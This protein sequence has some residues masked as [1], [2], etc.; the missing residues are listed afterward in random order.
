MP[1]SVGVLSGP[2]HLHLL[3]R[4]PP[5][6]QH[7]CSISLEVKGVALWEESEAGPEC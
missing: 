4:T 1:L 2:M 5:A 6:G 3:A 7:Q